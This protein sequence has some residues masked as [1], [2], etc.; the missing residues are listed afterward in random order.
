MK[1]MLPSSDELRYFVEVANA[2]NLTRAAER[3][4]VTQPSLSLALNRLE[5]AFGTKLLTRGKQG[6]RLTPAGRRALAETQD[7]LQRWQRLRI[8][9]QNAE[10]LPE[11]LI[12]VGCH[13]SVAVYTLPGVVPR[14]M[15][16]YPGLNIRLFHDLS[17]RI[18]ERVIQFELE[19]GLVIN[20]VQHPDLVTKKINSD[21]V[22]FWVAPKGATSV[23]IYDPDLIQAQALVR[24]AK[25]A[26]LIFE[27]E[28]HSSNLEVI[29]ELVTSG[30][31]VGILPGRVAQ[32]RNDKNLRMLPNTPVFKDE[33]HVLFRVENRLNA[34]IG[35]FVKEIIDSK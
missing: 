5:T 23:L 24:K 2:Q 18:T 27:K 20:P 9:T 11:G 28:I 7:L 33:L 32:Y 19:V 12:R 13:P 4:G 17:R 34:A 1:S 26:G 25:T 8:D 35:A 30:T 31:G 10:N 29:R 3:L 16:K 15:T 22:G 21:Q 6:V 14:L